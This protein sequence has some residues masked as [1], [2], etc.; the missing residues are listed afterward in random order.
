VTGALER[1]AA[2][3]TA[4]LDAAA[5]AGRSRKAARDR[6]VTVRPAP[7][8]MAYLTAL[9]PTTLGV[10]AYAAGTSYTDLVLGDGDQRGRGQ[11]MADTLVDRLTGGTI[12]GCH[13][14]GTPIRRPDPYQERAPAEPAPDPRRPRTP[15]GTTSRPWPMAEPRSRKS[16]RPRRTSICT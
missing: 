7:D 14:H 9:L 8:T 16:C 11:I 5:V 15:T 13:R 1:N 2:K 6:R 3:V 4:E 12:T 10:A